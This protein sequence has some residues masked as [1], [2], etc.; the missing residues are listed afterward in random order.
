DTVASRFVDRGRV[1]R[2][3]VVD[4]GVGEDV[5]VLAFMLQEVVLLDG[6]AILGLAV[7]GQAL[8]GVMP[9]LLLGIG[10]AEGQRVGFVEV[11]GQLAAQ[12]TLVVFRV[13][14]GA[15]AAADEITFFLIVESTGQL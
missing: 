6:L 8:A 10:V 5:A 15:V 4:V 11:P 12:V 7:S 14:R 9:A 2:M 1:F 13:R 3:I